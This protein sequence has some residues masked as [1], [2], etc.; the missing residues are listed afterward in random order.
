M[1]SLLE[2]FVS[3]LKFVARSS[4]GFQT[5][6]SAVKRDQTSE[7]ASRAKS[8]VLSP[9]PGDNCRLSGDSTRYDRRWI[10]DEEEVHLTMSVKIFHG[11]L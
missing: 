11:F 8:K 5:C 7:L 6:A 3:D 1:Q 2:N 10:F 4:T 9:E